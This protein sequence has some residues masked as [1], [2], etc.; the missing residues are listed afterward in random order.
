MAPTRSGAPR[1]RFVTLEGGE[2]AGKS[3][4]ARRLAERLEKHGI[5]VVMTREPGGSPGAEALRYVLLN[6]AAKS[7]G[8]DMEAMLFAAAR[9][10]HVDQVI[11]PA[12]K[13][14]EWVLCDRFADS[15]RVYQGG[16][17]QISPGLVATLEQVALDGVAAD[18]TLLLDIDAETGLA[19]ASRRRG[20][21]SADRF[22][23]DGLDVHERRRKAFLAIAAAEPRRVAVI[24][25]ALP[26]D[27]VA[28]A[29][30]AVVEAQLLAP[31]AGQG[32]APKSPAAPGRAP[33][34]PPATAAMP[35][36]G[37]SAPAPGVSA[38]APGVSASAAD[39][40]APQPE[41]STPDDD[42]TIALPRKPKSTGRV[43]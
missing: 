8:P 37:G 12:L 7:L 31:V 40:P 43:S 19:R 38:S 39:G 9:A 13:R 14:G 36:S 35:V 6:G 33:A 5:P 25:A 32:V 3:T 11:R 17:G 27:Q 4:Q 30:W 23:G 15:T 10:D 16:E 42:V 2:G 24:D 41:A 28:D 22:E 21:G 20:A 29:I 34:S 26:P 18:L 1:G